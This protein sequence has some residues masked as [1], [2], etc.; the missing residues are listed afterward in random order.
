M[1]DTVLK[2]PSCNLK[3]SVRFSGHIL[4]QYN[5]IANKKRT[6]SHFESMLYTQP[7]MGDFS[8]FGLSDF[9]HSLYTPIKC[10]NIKNLDYFYCSEI[11][12]MPKSGQ[13]GVRTSDRKYCPKIG[14]NGSDFGHYTSQDR[15]GGKRGHKLF[16]YKMV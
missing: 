13:T 9:V 8:D 14:H 3:F 10:I 15:L 1:Q 2:V 12:T 16:K 11:R 6:S 4:Y 7:L 5:C